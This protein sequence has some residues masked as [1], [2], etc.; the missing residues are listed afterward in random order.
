MTR[1]AVTF[2]VDADTAHDAM[3]QARAYVRSPAYAPVHASIDLSIIPETHRP[4]APTL[5]LAAQLEPM[6]AAPVLPM[7]ACRGCGTR[8][9]DDGWVQFCSE[10]CDTGGT[11]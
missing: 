10:A 1:W 8:L 7:I 6:A 3:A 4:P 5:T 11:P 2:I 9:I